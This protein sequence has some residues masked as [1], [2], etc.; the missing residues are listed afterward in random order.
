MTAAGAGL[1]QTEAGFQDA[2]IE[3]AKLRGWTLAHFRPARTNRGWR[4]P[5]QG[6]PGFPDL[7]LVRPPRVLFVELKSAKGRLTR[8]QE[9]WIHLLRQSN[10]EAYE[11]WP[12]DWPVIEAVLA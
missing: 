3:L 6:D 2:V 4:T 5:V 12:V 7:V 11:W 9:W 10:V 8:E 1:V